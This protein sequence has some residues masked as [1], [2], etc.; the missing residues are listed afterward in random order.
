LTFQLSAACSQASFVEKP[1]LIVRGLG[2]VATKVQLKSAS[3][4]MWYG[5]TYASLVATRV[6][7]A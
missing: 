2:S 1:V 4:D 3:A 6:S 5:F 7:T